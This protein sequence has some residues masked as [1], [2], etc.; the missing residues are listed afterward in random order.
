MTTFL[1]VIACCLSVWVAHLFPYLQPSGFDEVQT[2]EMEDFCQDFVAMSFDQHGSTVVLDMIRSM[3]YL[4]GMGLGQHQHRPSEFMAIPDHDVPFGLG[5]IPTEADYRYMTRLCKERKVELQ[6]LIHQLQLSDGASGTSASALATP[7]SLDRMSLKT[8]YFPYEI[9]EHK[10]FSEVG[11]IV[12]GVVPHDQYIDEMLVMS[13]SQIDEIVR[14]ELATLFDLFRVSTIEIAEEIQTIPAP[15]FMDEDI[16]DVLFDGPVGPIEGKSEFVDPPFSFDVLSGFISR[17]DDVSDSS[18]MDLSIFQYLPVSYDIT[19]FVLSS[20]TSQIFD[21]DNE[22]AQHDLDDDS[23]SAFDLDTIDQRVSLATEDIDVV[24]FGTTDQLRKLR[25]RSNL[26]IDERNNLIQL[27]KSYLD[28]F[29]W[30]YENM[31]G[32]DP[33]IVQHREKKDLEAAQYM[34]FISGR[35]PEWLA[36]VVHVPKKDGK[37]L[38]SPKDMEKTF[39]ITR[40]GT[41]CYRV[42]LFGLKNTRATYQRSVTTLFHDMMHRDVEVYVDDMIVK[43]RDRAYHLAALESFFERIRQFRLRLN[44]KK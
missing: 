13:M 19:L 39:F 1:C 37:I 24:D 32:L 23:S 44:P 28:V 6:Q 14:L 7:S 5:F 35:V 21:I 22:I 2:L 42:M 25:I 20:P 43:S 36:N 29:A 11:D 10:T 31:S 41:Y 15:E 17:S 18:F 8:L 16:V 30:S 3:S 27:L 38:M 34:I 40:W 9:D 12:D 26:F 33:F 4:P